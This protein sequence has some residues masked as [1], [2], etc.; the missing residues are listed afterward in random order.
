[1]CH[2]VSQCHLDYVKHTLLAYPCLFYLVII[3]LLLRIL[4]HL[5]LE[6]RVEKNRVKN[7]GSS[8]NLDFRISKAICCSSVHMKG[9]SFLR[10][11]LRGLAF[12]ENPSINLRWYPAN[13][14]NCLT[15]FCVFGTGNSFTAIIFLGSGRTPFLS[16]IWSKYPISGHRNSH[17]SGYKWRFAF[18]RRCIKLLNFFHVLLVYQQIW[19]CR[20]DIQRVLSLLIQLK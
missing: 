17:F 19:L 12:F 2:I 8:H 4:R 11:W 18:R 6:Q 7:S 9:V 20:Q 16:I 15:F 5:L 14:K 13:P 1:M 3:Y 10:I